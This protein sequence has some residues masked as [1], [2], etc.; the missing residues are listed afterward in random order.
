MR[1][2][3]VGL[4]LVVIAVISVYI[5]IPNDYKKEIK[6]TVSK[7][8]IAVEHKHIDDFMSCIS[9]SYRDAF[10]LAYLPLKRVM[11]DAF[12]RFNDIGIDYK[13]EEINLKNDTAEVKLSLTVSGE[14]DHQRYFIIGGNGADTLMLTVVKENLKWL[15]KKSEGLHSSL[16]DSY[17]GN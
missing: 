13:I 7:G 10:G 3:A 4:L 5:N 2:L 12:G 1:K 16:F 9:Y 15:V 17:L 6:K 8:K 14:A 11:T